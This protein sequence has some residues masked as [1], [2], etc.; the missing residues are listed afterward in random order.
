MAPN[1]TM[2]GFVVPNVGRLSTDTG[3]YASMTAAMSKYTIKT[4]YPGTDK[5][6]RFTIYRDLPTHIFERR[7]PVTGQPWMITVTGIR[8]S[9][10]MIDQLVWEIDEQGKAGE[11]W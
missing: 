8:K 11:S 6:A 9:G 1:E 3:G 4:N 2:P 7:C 10:V 5:G